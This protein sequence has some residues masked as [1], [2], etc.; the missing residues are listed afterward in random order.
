MVRRGVN[1]AAPRGHMNRSA[2]PT[3]VASY[4]AALHAVRFWRHDVAME[5]SFS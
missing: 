2:F 4:D 3:K 1:A 5:A